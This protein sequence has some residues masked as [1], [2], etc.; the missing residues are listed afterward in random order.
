[1]KSLAD[2][3]LRELKKQ[4]LITPL[5]ATNPDFEK[6]TEKKITDF[7]VSK[8]KIK[9]ENEIIFCHFLPLTKFD[10]VLIEQTKTSLIWYYLP[11]AKPD[12]IKITETPLNDTGDQYKQYFNIDI[13]P[14]P[15]KIQAI[16]RI[17][18]KNTKNDII[19]AHRC[20]ASLLYNI[21]GLDIHHV[22]YMRYNKAGELERLKT[23]L[24][25]NLLLPSPREF[26]LCVLHAYINDCISPED[27]Q[28]LTEASNKCIEA[29]KN[30]A[31]PV[32]TSTKE[33]KTNKE[34]LTQILTSFYKQN[35]SI[36]NIATANNISVPTIIKLLKEYKP[37]TKW[38]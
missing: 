20:V 17:H 13:S 23:T 8:F 5:K 37:L 26:H 9:P 18:N 22:D 12:K 6:E 24:N 29:L 14:L 30:Y 11:E 21:S 28:G 33:Y 35:E 4:S 31:F 3:Y 25:I 7:L 16:I 2:H 32:D 38:I 19:T 27:I 36:K 10:F 34:R 1:M 15:A